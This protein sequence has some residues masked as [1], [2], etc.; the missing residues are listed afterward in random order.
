MSGLR[1]SR[2]EVVALITLAFL[3]S[4]VGPAHVVRATD[5]NWDNGGAD[6]SWNTAANWSP[7]GVP[8][9]GDN[10]VLTGASADGPQTI[11]LDGL[12]QIGFIFADGVDGQYTFI[13]SGGSILSLRANGNALLTAD[14]GGSLRIDSD[15]SLNVTTGDVLFNVTPNADEILVNGDITPSGCC[16]NNVVNLMLTSRNQSLDTSV[17]VNGHH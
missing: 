8:G 3:G 6:N 11:D 5:F 12:Q 13:N 17:Q 7:N 4:V 2:F 1:C 14:G 10:I 15:I 16:T 9:V